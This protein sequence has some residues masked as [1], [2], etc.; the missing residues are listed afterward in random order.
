MKTRPQVGDVW[1]YSDGDHWKIV[2]MGAKYCH[3]E[4]E[5]ASWYNNKQYPIGRFKDN[6]WT[7]VYRNK[8]NAFNKLY[9]T[10]KS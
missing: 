10:L 5:H 9:L 4:L 1:K 2:S 7:L 3:I 6:R 8:E